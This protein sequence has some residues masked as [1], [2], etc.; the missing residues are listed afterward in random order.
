M[1]SQTFKDLFK[2]LLDVKTFGLFFQ[3]GLEA[4]RLDRYREKSEE[5]STEISALLEQN[6]G[7]LHPKR[8]DA[9]TRRL[10]ILLHK[11]V[12]LQNKS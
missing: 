4:K 12:L 11:R 1:S 7:N 3:A 9:N 8:R 10:S 2:P 5:L 6:R